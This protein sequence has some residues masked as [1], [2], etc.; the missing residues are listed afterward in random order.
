MGFYP[1]MLQVQNLSAFEANPRFHVLG[2]LPRPRAAP[3][4]QFLTEPDFL[5]LSR[6]R[7]HVAEAEHILYA[8]PGMKKDRALVRLIEVENPAARDCFL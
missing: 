7:V 1:D 8:D 2:H 3:G 5:S 4:Q 6:D